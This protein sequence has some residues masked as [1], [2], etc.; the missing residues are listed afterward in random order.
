MT[1]IAILLGA[2]L[3]AGCAS[4]QQMQPR[5]QYLTPQIPASLRDC[6]QAPS[7]PAIEAR[8]RRAYGHASQAEVATFIALM[9]DAHADCRAKLHSVV[10]LVS[11]VEARARAR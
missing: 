11:K 5:T 4:Q 3:L 8:A 7:W 2:L 1:R 6:R 9:S 10:R